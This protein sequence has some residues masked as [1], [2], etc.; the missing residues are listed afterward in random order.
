LSHFWA[1]VFDPRGPLFNDPREVLEEELRAPGVYYSLLEELSTGPK[2]LAELGRVLGRRTPDLQGY[3]KTL[4]GMRV[5]D[6]WAPVTARTD[7]R[8]HR[9]ALEDDFMRFW[10]RFVFPYQEDLK[11]WLPT[12]VLYR[13]EIAPQM[14]D[15]LAST[16][17]R[18]CQRWVLR[19]GTA[20]RV[21][22]WWGNALN[23]HRRDKSRMS[24]GV[25]VVGLTRSVVTVVGECKW[26]G[27][28]MRPSATGSTSGAPGA[29]AA[30]R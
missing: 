8:N 24:E 30:R 16:F 9:W 17:E 13:E 10:F 11:T 14:N 6:R 5:V 22:S 12:D 26:T 18:L 2:S 15:H 19:S 23:E 1:S 27:D 20:T 4:R 25:D 7:E 21:G 3:L 28:S 29:Q